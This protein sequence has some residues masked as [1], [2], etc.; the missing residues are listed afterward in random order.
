MQTNLAYIDDVIDRAVAAE[1]TTPTI[2]DSVRAE[3]KDKAYKVIAGF[4]IHDDETERKFLDDKT[5]ARKEQIK[6]FRDDRTKIRAALEKIGVTPLAVVPTSAWLEICL[7]T[8]LFILKPGSDGRIA[9]PVKAFA[10]YTAKQIE[11]AFKHDK[12]GLMQQ[13]FP[14]GKTASTRDA[15]MANLILPAPPPEVAA[16]LVKAKDMSLQ[17]AAVSDAI[18]F[19]E[20]PTELLN[21]S[22]EK[23]AGPGKPFRGF[24]SYEEWLAKCPIIYTEQGTATAV[25]AQFG[26]FPIEKAVVDAVVKSDKL[27]PEK[28]EPVEEL[29]TWTTGVYETYRDHMRQMMRDS[30]LEPR[31]L[32]LRD[33]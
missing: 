7:S 15:I 2:P 14:G 32:T 27:L 25:I 13:F 11:H 28:F 1:A 22:K 21:R 31:W 12:I 4:R 17:T 5:A 10:G 24:K 30:R 3:A 6:T 8:K 18:E 29:T 26:D 33:S 20:T 9:I 16:I 19:A 23:D